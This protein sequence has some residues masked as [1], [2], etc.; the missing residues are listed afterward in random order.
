[1]AATGTFFFRGCFKSIRRFITA[2][3]QAKSTWVDLMN[4]KPVETGF[5]CVAAPIDRYVKYTI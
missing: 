1:M 2:T 5:D 3:T 4:F